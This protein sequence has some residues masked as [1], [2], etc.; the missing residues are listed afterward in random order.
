MEQADLEP[1]R[2]WP[3]S[4]EIAGFSQFQGGREPTD[5]FGAESSSGGK[6]S[7][8]DLVDDVPK[9][10]RQAI[11]SAAVSI[12]ELGVIDAHQM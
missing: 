8:D 7:R 11:V 1:W 6:A 4:P 2:F 5:W 3:R 12:G 9:N 10:I